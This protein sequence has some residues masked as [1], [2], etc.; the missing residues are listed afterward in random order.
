M[1]MD[2]LIQRH[3]DG[4][5][6]AVE[7]AELSHLL[8][9]DA[10]ARSRYL[11]LAEL[12]AALAADESLRAPKAVL[13][14]QTASKPGWARSISQMA[15]GVVLGGLAVGTVWA[16]AMPK[17]PPS[18][19][20]PLV[21]GGFESGI[22]RHGQGV[23]SEIGRWA[24]DPREIVT[25]HGSVKPHEGRRMMR[26]KAANS[27]DDVEGGKRSS[28]DMWQVIALPGSGV[29]RVQV[30]A[31]FNAETQGQARFQ[32]LAVAGDGDAKMAPE[33]WKQNYQVAAQV[34]AASRSTVFADR[35]PQTWQP[36]E[37]MLQVPPTARVLVIG[38]QAFRESDGFPGQF[39]DDVSVSISEEVLP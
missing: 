31:W 14:P 25:T 3:L 21:D 28:S 17:T 11:D 35:D 30:R 20:L 34:P 6:S 23:P 16:Y 29:R 5:N 24:G 13:R 4:M 10:A 1:N 39:V 7:A 37:L 12:H 26:F 19:I 33:L 2:D 36:V 32:I 27:D 9:T 18:E 38:I 22:Q 8:E 15:A